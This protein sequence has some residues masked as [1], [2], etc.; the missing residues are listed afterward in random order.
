MSVPSTALFCFP[1]WPGI[2]PIIEDTA[3]T[4]NRACL[5]L[6]CRDDWRRGKVGITLN[7]PITRTPREYG[8]SFVLEDVALG[9]PQAVYDAEK[10]V[11]RK[12]G[13]YHREWGRLLP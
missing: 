12:T 8:H 13:G 2:G 10:W 5:Y 3:W 11:H 6:F 1:S 4:G 7:N 9:D